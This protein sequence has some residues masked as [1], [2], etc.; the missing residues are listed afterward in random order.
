MGYQDHPI[1]SPTKRWTVLVAYWCLCFILASALG[2]PAKV[3]EQEA[4]TRDHW[5]YLVSY[6]L[7]I[8]I[9]IGCYDYSAFAFNRKFSLFSTIVYPIGHM[10]DTLRWYFAFDLGRMIADA[11]I[12]ALFGWAPG[13]VQKLGGYIGGQAAFSLFM[14][15]HRA[16]QELWYLPE[17]RKFSFSL[18][19]ILHRRWPINRRRSS[20]VCL[21]T[22]AT[23]I[24]S[25]FI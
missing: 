2:V 8:P 25:S 16:N 7:L 22:L 21:L 19:S 18:S 24:A 5:M 14:I 9:G 13:W 6:L 23:T 10:N 3:L 12:G 4:K 17:H 11:V 1:W 15:Q 20:P